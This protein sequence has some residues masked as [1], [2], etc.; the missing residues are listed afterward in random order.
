MNQLQLVQPFFIAEAVIG[1]SG[2]DQLFGI[3]KVKV[4]A[5]TL[6]I[7]PEI[8][9]NVRPFIPVEAGFPQGTIDQI[10]RPFHIA[11][12]IGIFNAQNKFPIILRAIR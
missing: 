6:N 8:T 4:F 10:D 2:I 5:F 12:L 1:V 3:F 9:P 7:R 11:F